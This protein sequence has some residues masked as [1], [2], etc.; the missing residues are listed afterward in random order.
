MGGLGDGVMEKLPRNILEG[1]QDFLAFGLQPIHV[2]EAFC[3]GIE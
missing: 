2:L 3:A 1:S